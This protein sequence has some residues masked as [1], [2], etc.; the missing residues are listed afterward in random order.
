MANRVLRTS[1]ILDRMFGKKQCMPCAYCGKM[2]LRN[3]ATFDH[4]KALANG[5]YDKSSNGAIACFKCN[6]RKG[7][8]SVED[9]KKK[10]SESQSGGVA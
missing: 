10:L 2:L 4:K 6:M 5:G 3:A 9:F 7:T 1:Q 8:L